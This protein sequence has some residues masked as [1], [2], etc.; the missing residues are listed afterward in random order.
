M[1]HINLMFLIPRKSAVQVSEKLV[2]L[3]RLEL[4]AI[5]IVVVS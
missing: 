1:L 5:I 2:V 3:Q 4:I